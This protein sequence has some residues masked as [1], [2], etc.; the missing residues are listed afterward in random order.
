MLGKYFLSNEK[1][2]EICN[3]NGERSNTNS[4]KAVNEKAQFVGYCLLDERHKEANWK[5]QAIQEPHVQ[6]NEKKALQ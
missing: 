4:L 3:R 5:C 1:Q 2:T 6:R